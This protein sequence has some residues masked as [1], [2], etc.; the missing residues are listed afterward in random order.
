MPESYVEGYLGAAKYD[1]DRAAYAIYRPLIE[2][3]EKV[4]EED[5]RAFVQGLA[6][7]QKGAQKRVQLFY[8]IEE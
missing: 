8:F 5:V 2:K 1:Y 6:D 3:A 4:Y 7:A